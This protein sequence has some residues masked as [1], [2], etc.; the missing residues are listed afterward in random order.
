MYSWFHEYQE[1]YNP[2]S[3]LKYQELS[4]NP[5]HEIIG[6]TLKEYLCS[7][8]EFRDS[9]KGR[10]LTPNKQVLNWLTK[11]GAKYRHVGLT[12]RSKQTI[13][14]LAEWTFHHFGDWIRTLSFIPANREGESLPVYDK[15]K[16]DF[17]K[18]LEKA[19]FYV[20]DL[21]EN[22][23]EAEEIGI[24]AFLF[25]QPWNNGQLATREILSK[26]SDSG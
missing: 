19:D 26:I 24:T 11:D 17:L 8:D 23:K 20:D 7:L 6:I 10:S 2:T 25:P 5:P 4:Q 15:S 1:T 18:W 3:T 14:A 22:V 12:A 21:S 13:P 9:E 16:T